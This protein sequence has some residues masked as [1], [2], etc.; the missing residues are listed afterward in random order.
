MSGR[1]VRGMLVTAAALILWSPG[2]PAQELSKLEEAL[3]AIDGS[4]SS[5]RQRLS[6]RKVIRD[7]LHDAFVRAIQG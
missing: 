1:F 5:A 2:L 6:V 4:A 7:A 3:K